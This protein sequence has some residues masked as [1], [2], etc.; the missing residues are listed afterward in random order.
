MGQPRQRWGWHQL[1]PEHAERLVTEADLPARA[2][3]LD[4]GAGH[5]A[6]T[7]PLVDAGHR[8]VAVEA[9]PGRA[10]HLR[11]RFGR[12]ITVVQADARDLRLPR[13]PFHVVASPPY[14]IT[15]PL[16]RAL[17]APR[18]R[19]RSA[20]LV[21][22]LQAARRFAD[23]RAPGAG[24]WMHEYELAVVRPVPR[25]AFRPPPAVPSAVLRIRRRS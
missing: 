3:V 8:V 4:V 16:L 5:G 19:L 12:N 6:L 1:D 20:H 21:V 9:H 7:A 23:G 22:Q 10:A 15:T 2:L 25:R 18:G 14:A 24:R 11:Q 17:L 13:R